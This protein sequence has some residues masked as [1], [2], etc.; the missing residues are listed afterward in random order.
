MSKAKFPDLRRLCLTMVV[1]EGSDVSHGNTP[2]TKE[3]R[4][5]WGDIARREMVKGRKS[6]EV[7]FEY[8]IIPAGRCL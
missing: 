7:K 2:K 8:E 5:F 4:E 6:L 1:K 3:M